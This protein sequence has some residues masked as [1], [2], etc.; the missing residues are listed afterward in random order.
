MSVIS[1]KTDFPGAV[2]SPDHQCPVGAINDNFTS[3]RLIRELT[4]FF[5]GRKNLVMI[6]LGCAGGQFVSDFIDT[7]NIGIGLE[8]STHVLNGTG[9]SNWEKYVDKNLFFCDIAKDYQLYQDGEPLKADI[10]HSEEVFEHIAEDDIPTLLENVKKH[11]K[12]EGICVLGISLSPDVQER[13]GKTY[14]LHQSVFPPEW[15]KSKLEEHGFEILDGGINIPVKHHWGTTAYHYGYQF[16]GKVREGSD[17]VYFCC[18]L[19]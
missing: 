14:V 10:I 13:D 15:W 19:K 7:K 9:K 2:D 12:P 17:S 4:K 16:K 5:G 8:G 1:L 6:D 18:K 11:L 3:L